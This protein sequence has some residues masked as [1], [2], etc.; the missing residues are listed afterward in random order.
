[1]G[2]YAKKNRLLLGLD[3]C[4][5]CG[6]GNRSRAAGRGCPTGRPRTCSRQRPAARPC[7]SC[8]TARWPT[9]PKP[10]RRRRCWWPR[11]VTRQ[12]PAW[13]GTR[14]RLPRPWPAGR[15]ATTRPGGG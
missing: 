2:G 6:I 8:G 11:A 10:A 9:T 15:S 1:M 13:P 12:W 3:L 7:T 14:G 5:S 4:L